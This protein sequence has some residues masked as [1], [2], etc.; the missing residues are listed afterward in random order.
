MLTA[1]SPVLTRPT[2]SSITFGMFP[3][4]SIVVGDEIR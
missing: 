1:A 4:D 3:A 2:N